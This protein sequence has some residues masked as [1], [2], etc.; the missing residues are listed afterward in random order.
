[1]QALDNELPGGEDLLWEKG[2]AVYRGSMQGNLREVLRATFPVCWRLVG[3]DYFNQLAKA[4]IAKT[5]HLQPDISGYGEKFPAFIQDA[6]PHHQLVYLAD[7]AFLEWACHLALSGPLIPSLNKEALA[8]VASHLQPALTFALYQ[9]STLVHSV[10]PILH[11]WQVN[12]EGYQGIED[13]SLDEG[14][15]YLLVHR[16]HQ[17]LCLASLTDQKFKMLTYFA[18]KMPFEAVCEK[19]YEEYPTLDIPRLFADCIKQGYLVSFA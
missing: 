12:Q 11:I 7:V 17:E 13:I 15:T 3:E 18:A 5:P 6:L 19:C 10:Y 1:M 2:L 9:N 8:K 4:Y 16:R 14:E